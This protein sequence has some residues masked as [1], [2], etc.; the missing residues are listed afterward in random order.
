[1]SECLKNKPFIDFNKDYYAPDL[2][3][4]PTQI[5]IYNADIY[6]HIASIPDNSIDLIITDPPYILSR[7]GGRWAA[8][9]GG[10]A[11]KELISKHETLGKGFDFSLLDELERIQ[12]NVNAYIFCNQKL[13]NKII[14]YYEGK[15]H[16]TAE[17][18]IWHKTNARPH[19]RNRYNLDIEFILYVYDKGGYLDTTQSGFDSRVFTHNIMNSFNKHTTH[20]TEK[21][22]KLIENLVLNSSKEGDRVLDCFMGSGTTAHACKSLNRNFIGYEIDEQ[23]FK[24]AEKRLATQC[25]GKLIL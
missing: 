1:M 10:A 2:P 21:P 16:L 15:P 3:D 7:A 25:Q 19:P 17:V 22:L 14:A 18:L 4:E 13:L 12:S 8:L 24:M 11:Y 20:P 6:E 5:Q 23:Y 9:P